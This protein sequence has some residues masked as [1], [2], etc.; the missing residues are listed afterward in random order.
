MVMY[1]HMPKKKTE[2]PK[3]KLQKNYAKLGRLEKFRMRTVSHKQA[4][5]GAQ[6]RVTVVAK[7]AALHGHAPLRRQPE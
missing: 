5:K 4:H 7:W 3:T 6:T 1:E 2:N